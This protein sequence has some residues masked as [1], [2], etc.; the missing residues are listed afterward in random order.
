MIAHCCKPYQTQ[1]GGEEKHFSSSGHSVTE[2]GKTFRLQSNQIRFCKIQIDGGIFP[3]GTPH[4]KCDW[5][6][7]LCDSQHLY[8]I[9]LKGNG[10]PAERSVEQIVSTI[11]FF[12]QKIHPP[13]L[14]KNQIFGIVVGSRMP[15]NTD[16]WRKLQDDFRKHHGQKLDRQDAVYELTI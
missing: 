1:L 4:L 13:A 6:F 15:R 5:V 10:I 11:V 8:F 3:K 2:Q 9:E 16:R 12:K 7:V 14:A